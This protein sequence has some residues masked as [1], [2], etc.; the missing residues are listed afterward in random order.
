MITKLFSYF[1]TCNKKQVSHGMLNFC[2]RKIYV[3]LSL[4]YANQILIGDDVLVYKNGK[5][6]TEKV[7]DT[8]SITMQGKFT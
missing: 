8:S 3:R 7:I 1:E 2:V 6:T 4:R 5:L